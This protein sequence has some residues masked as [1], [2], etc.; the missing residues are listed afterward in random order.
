LSHGL[1]GSYVDLTAEEHV[2]SD[3]LA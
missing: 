3:G 2:R 1:V